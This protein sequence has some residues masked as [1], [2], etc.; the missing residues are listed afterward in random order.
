MSRVQVVFDGVSRGAEQAAART[1]SA[2]RGVGDEADRQD[3]HVSRFGGAIGGLAKTG[4]LAAGALGVGALVATLRS[5]FKEISEHQ[6]VVAQTTAVLKS[7]GGQAGMTAKEIETLASSLSRMSGIDDEAI[8]AGENLMLT[9]RHVRDEAGAGNDI[10]TQATKSAL[11]MSVALGTDLKSATL[12]LGKALDNPVQGMTAL[13]R[14]GV[15]FTKA[16]QDQVRALEKSGHTLEAQKVILAEVS[17]E[18]GGSAKAAGETLPGQLAKLKVEWD[19]LSGMLVQVFVPALTRVVEALTQAVVW[20]ETN[21]PRIKKT[22]MDVFVQVKPILDGFV[23]QIEGLVKIIDGLFKGDWSEVW[24]GMKMVVVG[25]IK[26]VT[27]ALRL[28]W[29]LAKKAALILAQRIYEGVSEGL[30]ALGKLAADKARDAIAAY[31]GLYGSAF[32]AARRF[33]GRIL[34]GVTDGLTGI[35]AA[36]AEKARAGIGAVTGLV[37]A[38]AAAARKFGSGIL[39]GIVDGLSGL[40]GRLAALILAPINAVIGMINGIRLPGVHISIGAKKVAGVTVFPGVTLSTPSVDPFP[41]DIPRLGFAAGGKVPG[42]YIGRD[43]V[44]ALLS[45]GEYVLT[46]EQ[47]KALETGGIGGLTVNISVSGNTMLGSEP[48]VAAELARTIE[49]ELRRLINYQ[50]SR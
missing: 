37:A 47:T 22:I 17:K 4:L 50:A 26:E 38:A 39:G 28:E 16:Q 6:R 30:A 23:E 32:A 7:T 31:V 29:E 33:G 42:N 14:A 2:I 19:N 34:D 20:T 10:F 24:E 43:S 5:G 35:A 8:Q 9:F 49:P 41:G 25:R 45:P 15:S 46:R 13:R 11:D 36:V 27:A 44:P 48:W 1:R 40:P 3:R 18:F 12:Q 21:W